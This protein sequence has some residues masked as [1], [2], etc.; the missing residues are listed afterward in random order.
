M[1]DDTVIHG[2]HIDSDGLYMGVSGEAP[3]VMAEMMADQFKRGGGIN[4][5]EMRFE[6]KEVCP[7]EWFVVTVQKVGGQTAHQLRAAAEA[8]IERL[9]A[10]VETLGTDNDVLRADVLETNRLR[11]ERDALLE[12]QRW[13]DEVGPPK[14]PDDERHWV[15]AYL[16][17][18][19][20]SERLRAELADK[21]QLAATIATERALL[22]IDHDRLR[23]E[24]A[25]CREGR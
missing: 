17:F 11:A 7:G 18:R 16:K 23:A 10:E 13:I 1:T 3:R 22:Q 25:A 9:R 15:G 21:I 12:R 24:L 19:A 8:E 14:H 20:E 4:Y 2:L 6:S 5:I